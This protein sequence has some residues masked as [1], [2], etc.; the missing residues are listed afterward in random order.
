MS[1]FK[2]GFYLISHPAD[3]FWDLKHE[4][5]G[6]FGVAIMIMLMFFIS[7]LVSRQLTGWYFNT[8]F[9]EYLNVALEFVSNVGPYLLWIVS[10]WCV[11]SL[12]DGQGTIKDISTATFYALIPMMLANFAATGFSHILTSR[13]GMMLG[14]I[15]GFGMVWSYGLIF[16]SVVI[17]HQ[18]TVLKG[19]VVTILSLLG[20]V[21]MMV[22]GLLVW[23]LVQQL[24]GFGW[25]LYTEIMIRLT[26]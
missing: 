6:S 26:E 5:R 25:E 9:T 18:Y 10:L 12:M 1:K 16:L 17:T 15:L 7:H 13:E 21:I 8:N 11:T 4:K 23:F 20:M 22:L 2:Y 3:G 19:V 24:M 14:L